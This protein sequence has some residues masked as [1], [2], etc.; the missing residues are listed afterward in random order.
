MNSW[1]Q[2]R[3]NLL[4]A[5]KEAKVVTITIIA[6]TIILLLQLLLTNIPLLIGNL[7]MTF[8]TIELASSIILGLLFGI[9]VGLLYYKLKLAASMNA[10]ESGGTLLGAI[11]GLLVTGCP[12]CT[13]TLASYIGL[14][15][16]L[17][18]LP[19]TGL[20]IKFLGIA[21]LIYS[22]N[23]LLKNLTTCTQKKK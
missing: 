1:S 18:A 2:K 19:F 11:F 12:A 20:E 10:K 23:S 4:L 5:Y 8:A 17:S 15:S 13:I 7:G 22:T 14:A 16:I 6:A 3:Q 9:N 21:L